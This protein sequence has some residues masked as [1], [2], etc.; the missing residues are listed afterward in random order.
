[1]N[2]AK[3]Q[4]HKGDRKELNNSI[5]KLLRMSGKDRFANYRDIIFHYAGELSLQQPDTGRAI[6][7]CKG[8]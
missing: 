7:H 4:R 8:V 3:M 1:M 5:G 6:Q 2:N